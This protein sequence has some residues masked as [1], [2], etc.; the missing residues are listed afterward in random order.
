MYPIPFT[1]SFFIT[2][3]F[4]IFFKLLSMVTEILF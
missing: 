4:F 1:L 2:Y 3:F